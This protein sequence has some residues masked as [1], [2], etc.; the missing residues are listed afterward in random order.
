MERNYCHIYFAPKQ[1]YHYKKWETTIYN[2]QIIAVILSR[3]GLYN[4]Q[5]LSSVLKQL[6]D[7]KEQ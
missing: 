1:C 2:A 3:S 7:S 6:I 5:Q 4:K